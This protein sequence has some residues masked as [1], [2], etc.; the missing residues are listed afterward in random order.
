MTSGLHQCFYDLG[1]LQRYLGGGAHFEAVSELVDDV[2][3]LRALEAKVEHVDEFETK[4]FTSVFD[5]RFYR[6]AIY[7]IV[8]AMRPTSVIETGV[9]HGLTSA[10]ILRALEQN[11]AGRLTSI[12]LPSYPDQGPPIRMAM[13][14]LPSGFD[15]G[16]GRPTV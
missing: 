4:T 8:R 2:D 6:V 15:L 9:L 10:F 11:R 16:V 13:A 14:C 12:D 3:L 5:F 7:A 1:R